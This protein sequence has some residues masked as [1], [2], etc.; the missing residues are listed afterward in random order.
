MYIF[1]VAYNLK[2]QKKNRNKKTW[3]EDRQFIG[4]RGCRILMSLKNSPIPDYWFL[5]IIIAG[6]CPM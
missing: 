4:R 3:N 6:D 1:Y 2:V 5:T